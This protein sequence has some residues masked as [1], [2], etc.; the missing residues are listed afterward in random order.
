MN[1]LGITIDT[2]CLR[3]KEEKCKFRG[4]SMTFTNQREMSEHKLTGHG[5]YYTCTVLKNS[6]VA[7]RMKFSRKDVLDRHID[8]FHLK[9][10]VKCAICGKEVSKSNLFNH[11]QQK[12]SQ[13]KHKCKVCGQEFNS[14]PALSMHNKRI[15]MWC[16]GCN[17]P[18][19]NRREYLKHC[20]QQHSQGLTSDE[21][22]L[23][24]TGDCCVCKKDF[25]VEKV[26]PENR[27]YVVQ[28]YSQHFLSHNMS[29]IDCYKVFDQELPWVVHT[30]DLQF[31]NDCGIAV[32][33]SKTQLHER[34][35]MSNELGEKLS[36][37]YKRIYHR[38]VLGRENRMP[39]LKFLRLEFIPELRSGLL[40]WRISRRR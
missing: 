27:K 38:M 12:H 6:V 9:K 34:H 7:C 30:S 20:Y 35:S 15:H 24:W 1:S 8:E 23:F 17:K 2:N 18:F 19:M 14:K 29:C 32:C 37:K 28:A 31:C 21:Q 33:G 22:S 10:V 36:K 4:C 26:L 5:K 39:D 25:K 3:G 16:K 13:V 40:L 11:T